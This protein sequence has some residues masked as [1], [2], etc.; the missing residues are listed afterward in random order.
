MSNPLNTIPTLFLPRIAGE[1]LLGVSGHEARWY[2]FSDITS[3]SVEGTE[4]TLSNAK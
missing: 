1:F 4:L 3:F 2:R